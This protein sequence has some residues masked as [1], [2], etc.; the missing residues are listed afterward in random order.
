MTVLG[1]PA[2]MYVVCIT[3]LLFHEDGSPQNLVLLTGTGFLALGIYMFHR[4][5]AVSVQEMQK[6]HQL[7]LRHHGVLLITSSI[8]ITISISV[9]ALHK[10]FALLLVTGSIV[11]ILIYG[12]KL[13]NKPLRNYLYLKPLAVGASIS[14][15]GW[16]LNDFSNSVLVVFGVGLLCSA[17]ALVCDLLDSEYDFATNC[18]T[19][20]KKFGE[21]S[22]LLVAFFF[23][24]I[25]GLILHSYVGWIFVLLF[26][27][28]L[29]S[30]QI[31]RTIVDF[32][33]LV[34]LLIAWSL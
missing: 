26:P 17:D 25:F 7:A 3:A 24:L 14:L 4:T 16:A 11:G 6:R 13:I 18:L 10:P 19:F 8:C 27:I 15:L 28:P 1:F 30:K 32:R 23:Y 21:Q 9:F 31:H 12:K 33:P 29:L 20:A 5:N 2:A 22:T 34:V